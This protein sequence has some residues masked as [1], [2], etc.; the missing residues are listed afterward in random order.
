VFEFDIAQGEYANYYSKLYEKFGGDWKGLYY[1]LTGLEGNTQSQGF[2][3]GLIESIENSNRA[4]WE[5][6]GFSFDWFRGKVFAGVFGEE[7]YLY[8]GD[9]KIS[10]KLRYINDVNKIGDLKVPEMKKL[11]NNEYNSYASNSSNYPPPNNSYSGD[12]APP[13]KPYPQVNQ[14]GFYTVEDPTLPF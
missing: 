12:Y 2:F 10:C 14:E 9:I 7:E 8:N 13:S 4:S 1:Q 11:S 6:S 5:Q 3:K